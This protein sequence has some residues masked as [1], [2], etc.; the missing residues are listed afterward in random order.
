MEAT[1][2]EN[3]IRYI[4]N[5]QEPER[6]MRRKRKVDEGITLVEYKYTNGSCDATHICNV[7]NSPSN[8][9]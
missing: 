7:P 3:T 1:K 6:D 4:D 9:F 8:E 2:P 5:G